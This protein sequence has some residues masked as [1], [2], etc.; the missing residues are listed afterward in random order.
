MGIDSRRQTAIELKLAWFGLLC[1]AKTTKKEVYSYF[2]ISS[3]SSYHQLV[4]SNK[5]QVN[6]PNFLKAVQ[7][8][9]WRPISYTQPTV[10]YLLR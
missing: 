1:Y 10:F 3:Y 6:A 4:G 2:I 8:I 5:Q 7:V 9:L